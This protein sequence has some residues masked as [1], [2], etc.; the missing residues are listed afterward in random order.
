M[1][2]RYY[3]PELG[4]WSQQDP[5]G[6]EANAY[7]YVNSNP[8]NFVDPTG[9]FCVFGTY[10]GPGGGS[11]GG[12]VNDIDCPFGQTDAGGCNGARSSEE[13]TEAVGKTAEVLRGCVA[14]AAATGVVGA[15]IGAKYRR[16]DIGAAV[17]AGIGC[18]SGGFE[19][20]RNL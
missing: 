15:K 7:L 4:R 1:G 20:G 16:P 14:G 12:S 6:Q 3:Q 8:V 13:V 17:G 9:L 5:S 19:A 18:V 2:A 10:G 11:R